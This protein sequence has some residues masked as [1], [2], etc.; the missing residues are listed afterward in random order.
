MR[1][2]DEYRAESTRLQAY[3]YS[4]PG[5]YFV[6]ICTKD[7]VLCLSTVADGS[8]TLTPI[9]EIIKEEWTRTPIV[10]PNIELDSWVIMPNHVH[11][12]I[13]IT[14]SRPKV[15]VE[16]FRR[17]VSLSPGP[18]SET[19]HRANAETSQRGTAQT[20]HRGVSTNPSRLKRNSLGSIIGQIKSICTKRSRAA[21]FVDFAWQERYYDE[22]IRDEAALDRIRQY[23]ID[24][25]AR[26]HEDK[27]NPANLGM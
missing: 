24:N 8:V 9:G 5:W 22:I 13:V 6:T 10:R 16:T 27:D 4:S 21:G 1:F 11:G 20:P 7:H 17:N 14:D 25:P 26:W 23:I 3:D 19:P 2:K 12:I 18:N 15:G